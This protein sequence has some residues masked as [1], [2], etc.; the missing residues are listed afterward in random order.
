MITE[1][2]EVERMREPA[3][4]NYYEEYY[5]LDRRTAADT[6]SQLLQ[7]RASN[8]GTHNSNQIVVRRQGL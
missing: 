7:H 5:V 8:L 1:E 3:V 2:E 6:I 4:V